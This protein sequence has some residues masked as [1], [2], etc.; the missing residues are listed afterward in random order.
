MMTR[1]K[2]GKP[3]MPGRYICVVNDPHQGV[4]TMHILLNSHHGAIAFNDGHKALIDY[5][6]IMAYKPEEERKP[7]YETDKG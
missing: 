7:E 5:N 3:V 6:T 2:C 1:W 4:V